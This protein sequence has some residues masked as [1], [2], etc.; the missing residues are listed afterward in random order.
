MDGVQQVVWQ[1]WAIHLARG[2]GA[3][4]DA[5]GCSQ[6]PSLCWG[7]KRSVEV[8]RQLGV[9]CA[10][11][12]NERPELPTESLPF[13]PTKTIECILDDESGVEAHAET[14]D[15]TQHPWR[16]TVELGFRQQNKDLSTE[17]LQGPAKIAQ[18]AVNLDIVQGILLHLAQN[19]P[20][21]MQLFQQPGNMLTVWAGE[22]HEHEGWQARV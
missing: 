3:G 11:P 20:H 1:G 21:P 7:S 8:V 15:I 22:P 2:E 12:S 5:R 16:D 18:K 9:A 6:L 14:S 13:Q 17:L 4:R 10:V 19:L